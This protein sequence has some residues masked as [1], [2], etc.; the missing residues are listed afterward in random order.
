MAIGDKFKI[1]GTKIWQLHGMI[2]TRMAFRIVLGNDGV[3]YR[4]SLPLIGVGK[5][6]TS[7]D[8]MI[9]WID[10][11]MTGDDPLGT[12]VKRNQLERLLAEQAT[13]EAQIA[14]LETDLSP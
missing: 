5:G 6:F 13:R 2:E 7:M 8:T 9:A 14:S 1:L 3:T 12:A 10:D 4:L 11:L